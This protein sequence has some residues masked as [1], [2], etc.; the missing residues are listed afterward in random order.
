MTSTRDQIAKALMGAPMSP[1]Y[2]AIGEFLVEFSQLEYIV[3]VVYF[4]CIGAAQDAFEVSTAQ[5]LRTICKATAI[6][7]SARYGEQSAKRV[8]SLLNRVQ[9]VADERNHIAH[10]YWQKDAAGLID[11]FVSNNKLAAASKYREVADIEKM[12]ESVR[13]LTGDILEAYLELNQKISSK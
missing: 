4:L 11:Q 5:P 1:H 13:V 2:R 12:T 7:C 9:T 10:A 8:T 3:K 6:L